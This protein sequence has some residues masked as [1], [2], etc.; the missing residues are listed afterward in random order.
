MVVEQDMTPTYNT[1]LTLVKGLSKISP[2]FVRKPCDGDPLAAASVG[3]SQSTISESVNLPAIQGRFD[4]S[5]LRHAGDVVLA[6]LR[7]AV[8]LQLVTPELTLAGLDALVLCGG[9]WHVC[10]AFWIAVRCGGIEVDAKYS[11]HHVKAC[12]DVPRSDRC[13]LYQGMQAVGAPYELAK[14]GAVVGIESFF[15]QQAVLYG[16]DTSQAVDLTKPKPAAAAPVVSAALAASTKG[17]A[18]RPNRRK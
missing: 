2:G 17:P 1:L 11:K 9:W 12:A 18:R 14:A 16:I 8:D 4:I 3:A 13:K 10:L 5:R 15:E 7:Y 6:A